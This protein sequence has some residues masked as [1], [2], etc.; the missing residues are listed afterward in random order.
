[1]AECNQDRFEFASASRTR[2]IVAELIGGTIT[3]AGSLLL[4]DTDTKMNLLTRF[5]QCFTDRQSPL[6][7]EHTLEQML[8]QRVYGLALGYEDVNDHDQLRLDPA[9]FAGLALHRPIGELGTN[10]Q[11][12]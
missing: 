5:S 3:D 7:I 9:A 4:K 11:K 12:S 6:L 10:R 2:Q 8:R 1:M